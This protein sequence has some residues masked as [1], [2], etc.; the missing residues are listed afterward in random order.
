LLGFDDL[1]QG[2]VLAADALTP[3]GTFGIGNLPGWYIRA[4]R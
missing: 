4:V 2:A 3:A 1:G